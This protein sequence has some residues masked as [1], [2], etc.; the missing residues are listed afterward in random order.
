M[1]RGRDEWL[2]RR[3]ATARLVPEPVVSS[4]SAAR[5]VRGGWHVTVRGQNLVPLGSPGS[6]EVGGMLLTDTRFTPSE[7]T[8][9]LRSMPRTRQVTVDLGVRR[10]PPVPL[11]VTR[12]PILLA[13]ERTSLVEWLR[14]IVAGR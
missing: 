6:V 10:V 9:R 4:A 5:R 7:I 14:R 1:S 12:R 11:R 3:A 2:A 13:P 8:G